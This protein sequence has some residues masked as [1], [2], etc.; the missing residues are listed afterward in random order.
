MALFVPCVF[1]IVPLAVVGLCCSQQSA[2]QTGV[3][4]LKLTKYQ[5]IQ[6]TKRLYSPVWLSF[7]S[8]ILWAEVF[9]ARRHSSFQV[10]PR[11]EGAPAATWC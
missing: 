7:L 1:S 6:N 11:R 4:L 5:D 9:D 2:M 3:L 10:P 8:S